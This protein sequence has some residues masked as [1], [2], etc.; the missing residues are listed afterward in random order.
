MHHPLRRTLPALAV[1]GIAVAAPLATA[2]T[3]QAHPGSSCASLGV[4]YS[5][6]GGSTWTAAGRMSAPHGVIS[7]KLQGQP[8]P[9]CTYDV[10]LASYSTQGPT[11]QTSGTQAFLGWATATLG[12]D[13]PPATLDV[14]AHLPTC[15]GQ[16]DLYSGNEKFDGK[17][18]PLPHYPNG[19][20]P[21]NLITAWNGGTACQPTPSPSPSVS[22]SSSPSTK[23]S[24]SPSTSPSSSPSQ[25]ASGTPSP[26]ASASVS[27]STSASPSPSVSASVSASATPSHSATPSAAPSTSA[28]VVPTPSNSTDTSGQPVGVPSV[29]P[30]STAPAEAKPGTSLAF[31][32]SNGGQ[33]IAT[34]V[35]GAALLALGTGAVVVS[36]RRAARR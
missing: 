5:T 10:S 33:M 16:I 17:S 19:V 24:G 25:S 35:G 34:A 28:A 20:F 21:R 26:S 4:V 1:L 6:D 23:P 14:S 7:V 9:G 27:P 29:Q 31:T 22:A 12:K 32:G 8:Q 11:W 2:G 13:L 15:F 3:A 30:V 18:N 36:R